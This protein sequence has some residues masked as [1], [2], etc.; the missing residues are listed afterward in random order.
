MEALFEKPTK[1][2]LVR[3]E[4]A[5]KKP[6]RRL[7]PCPD[8]QTLQVLRELVST[9]GGLLRAQQHLFK[10]CKLAALHLFLDAFPGRFMEEI[11]HSISVL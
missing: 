8:M 11:D 2:C 1:Q 6:S 9:P 7:S 3:I 5:P 10:P 4:Q